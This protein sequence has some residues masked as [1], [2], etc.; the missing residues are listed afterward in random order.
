MSLEFRRE[1]EISISILA[2]CKARRIDEIVNTANTVRMNPGVVNCYKLREK[3]KFCQSKEGW[4]QTNNELRDKSGDCCPGSQLK[5]GWQRNSALDWWKSAIKA[6]FVTR[7]FFK[8]KSYFLEMILYHSWL[9]ILTLNLVFLNVIN[10]WSLA[11]SSLLS[12]L[13]ACG[14]LRGQIPL[15]FPFLLCYS[16]IS[17]QAGQISFL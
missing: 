3:Y 9:C 14:S 16:S 15:N 4:E 1:F 11:L 8:A 2:S 13:P 12:L 6:A 5:N 7:F 10:G 17:V